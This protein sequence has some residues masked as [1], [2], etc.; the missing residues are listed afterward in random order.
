MHQQKSK[1]QSTIVV[2][3]FF[4]DRVELLLDLYAKCRPPTRY[5]GMLADIRCLREISPAHLDG[6]LRRG[7]SQQECDYALR[8]NFR[9]KVKGVPLPLAIINLLTETRSHL[10]PY[11]QELFKCSATVK[12]RKTKPKKRR[13]P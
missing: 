5:P 10:L 13:K 7:L 3:S 9:F 2:P 8:D 11:Y 4:L 12:P 6:M 1:I